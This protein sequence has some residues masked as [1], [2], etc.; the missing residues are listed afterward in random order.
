MI[1][2]HTHFKAYERKVKVGVENT[3][4]ILRKFVANDMRKKNM[5]LNSKERVGENIKMRVH[6][7]FIEHSENK[8]DEI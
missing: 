2:K 7:N 6:I 8:V 4:I 1:N 3:H 5:E